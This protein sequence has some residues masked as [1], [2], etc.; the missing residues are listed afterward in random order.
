MKG[1]IKNT[2]FLAKVGG[3]IVSKIEVAHRKTYRDV[4]GFVT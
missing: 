1:D 2:Q 4:K 3:S